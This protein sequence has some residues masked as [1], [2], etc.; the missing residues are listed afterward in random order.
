MLSMPYKVSWGSFPP[1]RFLGGCPSQLLRSTGI[2]RAI[3]QRHLDFP[4]ILF[5]QTIFPSA[6]CD[7]VMIAPK[8]IYFIAQ[9]SFF[10]L[11][12]TFSSFL[13]KSKTM[14]FW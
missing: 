6:S 13:L 11:Q 14:W 1:E 2:F 3:L 9:C 8:Y 10:I 12:V 5:L 4:V 7:L